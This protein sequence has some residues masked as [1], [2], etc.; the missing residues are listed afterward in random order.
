M[1]SRAVL[2]ALDQAIAEAVEAEVARQVAPLRVEITQLQRALKVAESRSR[3]ASK[4]GPKTGIRTAASERLTPRAIKGIRKKLGVSQAKFA[5]LAGVSP[6][7]VY[8]W[9]SGG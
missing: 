8:F 9:E 2:V 1:L 5:V 3:S 6:V 7:S 4:R